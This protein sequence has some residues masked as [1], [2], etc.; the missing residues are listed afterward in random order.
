MKTGEKAAIG[1]VALLVAGMVVLGVSHEPDYKQSSLDNTQEAGAGR[2]QPAMQPVRVIPKG[3][4]AEALPEPASEGAK[5]L[6]LYCVQCHDL[7]PPGMHSAR[8]WPAV[9]Q[10]MRQHMQQRQGGMLIR[11]IRP[12]ERQWQQLQDYLVKHGQKI[13]TPES[14][15]KLDSAAS[16]VFVDYCTQCHDAP[17]PAGYAAGNWPR[18][19]LRMVEHM[20]QAGKNMPDAGDMEAINLFLQQASVTE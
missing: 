6:A 14:L 10:R 15:D 16:K 3:L 18:T 8:R 17:D 4:N 20:R 9:L 5:A 2:P 12:P 7:P 19:V 11:L 1:I 13:L